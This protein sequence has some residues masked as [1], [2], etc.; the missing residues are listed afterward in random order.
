MLKLYFEKYKTYK[1]KYINLKNQK[2]GILDRNNLKVCVIVPTYYRKNKSTRQNLLNMLKTLD[3]QTYKDFKLFLIG[4]D[5]E[6]EKE[7]EEICKSYKKD[8]YYF[9]N[10]FS[11]RRYK[12]NI[13]KNY[14]Y[15]GGT[16]ALRIGLEKAKKENYDLA[17]N[18]DDDDE[19]TNNHIEEVVKNAKEFPESCLYFTQSKFINGILPTKNSKIF[20]NNY[21]IQMGECVRAATCYNLNTKIY[22][23]V[24]NLLLDIYK[25]A[26][27]IN[28]QIIDEYDLEPTDG[29]IYDLIKDKILKGELKSLYIPKITVIKTS[30]MNI[31]ILN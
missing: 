21:I 3:N 17:F 22:D 26:T 9:N 20:Y 14:W 1:T 29:R 7:F 27:D 16:E 11:Y 23:I 6:D 18:L 13:A 19:W 24:H 4:D 8:I 5:Y 12:F 28:N 30:D 2:G 15:I 25:V 31:P 10:N